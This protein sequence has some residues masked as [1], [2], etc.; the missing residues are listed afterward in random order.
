VPSY[1]LAIE[2]HVLEVD[3]E[4][5]FTF[6]VGF[7]ISPFDLVSAVFINQQ[8][9]Q[10]SIS[11]REF[12]PA[13]QRT[14]SYLEENEGLVK[15]PRIAFSI[16]AVL[17][18][19]RE[20]IKIAYSLIAWQEKNI[21]DSALKEFKD[22]VGLTGD[23]ILPDW[24]YRKEYQGLLQESSIPLLRYLEGLEI[25]TSNVK[26]LASE[27]PDPPYM[28]QVKKIDEGI[29]ATRMM[30]NLGYVEAMRRLGG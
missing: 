29:S 14:V 6:A 20:F 23:F 1:Q 15:E 26:D 28:D 12:L 2:G 19:L 17:P 21:P 10:P 8:W 24:I 18:A 22:Q 5:F 3:A 30:I 25:A 9:G 7:L 27:L 11:K 4:A 16:E 13:L